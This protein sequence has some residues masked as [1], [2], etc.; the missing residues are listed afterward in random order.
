MKQGDISAT[1]IAT[2]IAA[3]SVYGDNAVLM[4][5]ET[6]A[7]G[8]EKSIVMVNNTVGYPQQ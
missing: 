4:L 3:M 5:W 7:G 6:S 2:D 8:L 1:H